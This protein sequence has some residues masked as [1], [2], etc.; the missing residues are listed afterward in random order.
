MRSQKENRDTIL[1]ATG[2]TALG[3]IGF[4]AIVLFNALLWAGG[5]LLLLWGV[6]MLLQK[7]HI[8]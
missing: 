2:A 6:L 1:A 7:A 4:I 3:V 5:P 8:I